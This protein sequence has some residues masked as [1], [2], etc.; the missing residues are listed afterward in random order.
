[1]RLCVV[2]PAFNESASIGGIIDAV[3]KRGHDILVIDDGSSDDTGAIARGKGV[4]L[5]RH[6]RNLGKGASLRE[7][8][9]YA[10][11]RTD[12]DAVIVM[13]GDGQH[14]VEDI[15]GFLKAASGGTADII[16][17][18]RMGYTKNMPPLRYLVNRSMSWMISALCGQHVP[19]T[20][21][22]FRL[23]TR[24]ALREI[25]ITTANYEIESEMLLAAARKGMRISSVPITTVYRGEHSDINPFI[26]TVRFFVLIAKLFVR[27]IGRTER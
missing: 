13:D 25:R 2:I 4:R 21:C 11:T 20:Q 26:D 15:E 1:M 24:R 6:D 18:N 9:E 27:R 23:L 16:V 3:R 22:G 14:R 19:D 8:F 10:R 7:G 5:I 17:G 12:C